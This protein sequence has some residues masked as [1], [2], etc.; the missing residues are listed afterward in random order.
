MAAVLRTGNAPTYNVGVGTKNHLPLSLSYHALIDLLL[1]HRRNSL[2]LVGSLVISLCICNS[3]S[4]SRMYAQSIGSEQRLLSNFRSGHFI[5]CERRTPLHQFVD[6]LLVPSKQRHAKRSKLLL[7]NE[8]S[9]NL[10]GA[11]NNIGNQMNSLLH[12]FDYAQYK[13]MDLGLTL[14]SWAMKTIHQMFMQDFFR[15][16]VNGKAVTAATSIALMERELGVKIITEKSQ[17]VSYEAVEYGTAQELLAYQPPS[18]HHDW[19]QIMQYHVYILQKLFRHYNNG[20]GH[21]FNRNESQEMNLRPQVCSTLYSLF[22]DE[23][24][25]TPYVVIHTKDADSGAGDMT[26]IGSLTTSQYLLSVLKEL[27]VSHHPIVLLSDGSTVSQM[28]EEE[29]KMDPSI[30]NSIKI[31]RAHPDLTGP[32]AMVGILS[33]V[34]I[35]TP[36]S[37]TSG[38]IA[39]GRYSLGYRGSTFMFNKDTLSKWKDECRDDCI[40]HPSVMQ[41]LI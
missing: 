4:M 25:T 30:A 16:I 38:F 2:A 24:N 8:P 12:A 10:P 18:F 20:K 36:S 17:L 21:D 19:K 37:A 28:V 3:S 31:V 27:G 1:K 41:K 26:P 29:L 32:E 11:T 40:F 23:M 13:D 6:N 5:M 35:G 39:R 22:G 14:D 33:S 34:Y 7:L 15:S 9:N